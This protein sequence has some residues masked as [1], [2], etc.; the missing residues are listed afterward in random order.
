MRTVLAI[1]LLV[2]NLIFVPCLCSARAMMDHLIHNLTGVVVLSNCSVYSDRMVLPSQDV[3]V[4][5]GRVVAIVPYQRRFPGKEFGP[6]EM[7]GGVSVEG[8]WIDLK[9]AAV[10]PG[11]IDPHS[12]VIGG[13][14]EEGPESMIPEARF[15]QIVNSGVTTLIGLLGTDAVSMVCSVS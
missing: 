12:H 11:F 1:T 6:V 9:G 10:V 14:G 2:V 5:G 7:A 15:S 13:G 3:V 8:L 4:A